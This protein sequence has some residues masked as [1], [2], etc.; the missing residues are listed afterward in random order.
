MGPSPCRQQSPHSRLHRARHMESPEEKP[1]AGPR[2]REAAPR[3]RGP[4][5]LPLSNF[6]EE[7]R[8]L[9]VLAG[10]AVSPGGLGAH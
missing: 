10:P 4:R 8:A 5:C 2:D 1:G 6:Q 7:L 3:R 9:L